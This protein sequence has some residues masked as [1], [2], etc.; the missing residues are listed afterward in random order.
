MTTFLVDSDIHFTNTIRSYKS[1]HV[2]KIT[3]LCQRE[4]INALICP[5]DLTDSGG[6]GAH[7]F[8]WYYGGRQ[9][10]LTPLKKQYVEILD[11]HLP[12]YLCA[13]NHDYNVPRPYI[14]HPVLK[15]IRQRHGAQRY[16]FELN[17]LHFICLDKC[18]N[19][20]GM[21][22]LRR[23][24]KENVGKNIVIFFHYNLTGDYSDWWSIKEK[25]DFYATIKDYN[26]VA[27]L[28]GHHHISTLTEWKGYKVVMAAA[29]AFAKCT[30][31]DGE[32]NVE[33]IS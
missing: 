27:L 8:C 7:I 11:K 20:E 4:K 1:D 21:A 33:F 25:E 26:I 31:A 3:D 30:Y 18:P 19:K 12:V 29:A 2:K 6:N 14:V 24:L 22:F 16:S 15:Y 13:G 28:V 5:G 10:Q 32:L 17:D 23:D 9:D